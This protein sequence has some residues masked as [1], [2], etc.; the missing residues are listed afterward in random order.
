MPRGPRKGTG[1]G[2]PEVPQGSETVLVVSGDPSVRQVVARVLEHYGYHALAARDI[3][4]ATRVSEGHNGPIH[5]VVVQVDP[6]GDPCPH[7]SDGL[8]RS[9]P[10]MKLLC[11][12]GYAA[13]IVCRVAPCRASGFL[14]MPFAIRDLAGAVREALDG[15]L[16]GGP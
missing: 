10:G 9:R 16:P 11:M 8:L 13:E 4:R 5:A 14:R 6:P 2:Q 1:E 7:D 12:S 3:R 15:P